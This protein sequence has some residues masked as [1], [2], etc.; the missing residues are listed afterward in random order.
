MMIRKKDLANRIKSLC[1]QKGISITEAER[2][3]GYS[4][5][6]I[7]SRWA[8]SPD[9]F[10]VLTKLTIL[11]EVLGVST[12]E[13]LGLQREPAREH[14]PVAGTGAAELLLHGTARGGIK[15]KKLGLDECEELH[16]SP[17]ELQGA[18]SGRL[19]AEAWL[20]SSEH[21]NFLL[22]AFCDDLG[23]LSEPME[24]E[25]FSV[26]G[27][28]L[29]PCQTSNVSQRALQSLYVQI[30]EQSAL[31]RLRE[32]VYMEASKPLEN[33]EADPMVS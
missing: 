8:S 22:T 9:D 32:S 10:G 19:F 31:C 28:G 20:S 30:C 25:L 27:H 13:L 26:V 14:S 23:D 29:P 6:M 16:I 5:G 24:L 12:D 33:S 2:K 15:W 4:V 21:T 1:N 18:K 11:A 7:S 17:L 3:S